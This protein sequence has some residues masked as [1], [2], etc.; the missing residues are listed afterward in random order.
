[1]LGGRLQNNVRA[2]TWKF[3][4]DIFLDID[5]NPIVFCDLMKVKFGIHDFG[6]YCCWDVG[7]SSK[8][9]YLHWLNI[10]RFAYY[11]FQYYNCILYFIFVYIYCCKVEVKN[12]KK[13]CRNMTFVW[14]VCVFPLITDRTFWISLELVLFLLYCLFR[15]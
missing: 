7:F 8:K 12:K 3:F 9:W 15:K 4:D 1:M 14:W 5:M 6:F 2:I 13:S 10:Y 11:I